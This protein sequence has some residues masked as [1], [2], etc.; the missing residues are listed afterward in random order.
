MGTTNRMR[1]ANRRRKNRAI[2]G[3]VLSKSH[4]VV[5]QGSE[6]GVRSLE[7]GGVA[8]GDRE[9]PT[10]IDLARKREQQAAGDLAE[11]D[12]SGIPW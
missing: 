9:T 7:G 6:S 3:P 8:H 2:A 4:A 11:I 1:Y 10:G 5:D 12:W